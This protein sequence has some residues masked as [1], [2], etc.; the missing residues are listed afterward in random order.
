MDDLLQKYKERINSLPIAQSDK[1]NLYSNL[2]Q[3][4]NFKLMNSFLDTLTDEQLKL[5]NET[6]SDE[7][8]IRVYFS[9]LSESIEI[10]EFLQFIEQVYT[11]AMTKALSELPSFDQT[12][13]QK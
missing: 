3:E 2:T 10:P 4:L 1:D 5:I 11:V 7:E 6:T 8:T 12:T 9:I 13:L